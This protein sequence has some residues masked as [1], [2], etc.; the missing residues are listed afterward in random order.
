M[1]SKSISDLA[2]HLQKASETNL[3]PIECTK[4]EQQTIN[5]PTLSALSA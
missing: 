5:P 1:N 2:I 3:L 4:S